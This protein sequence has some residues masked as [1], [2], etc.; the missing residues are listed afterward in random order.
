M[1]CFSRTSGWWVS[2]EYLE[3]ILIAILVIWV[4]RSIKS[5]ADD[6]ATWTKTTY[7]QLVLRHGVIGSSGS[8]HYLAILDASSKTF[9]KKEAFV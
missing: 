1:S 9:H 7:I 6:D 8:I 4:S 3:L 5:G 2:V